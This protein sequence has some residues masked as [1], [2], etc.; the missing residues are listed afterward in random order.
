M[1]GLPDLDVMFLK[2]FAAIMLFVYSQ[3]FLLNCAALCSVLNG[4]FVAPAKTLLSCT[5]V[6]L[7]TWSFL[8]SNRLTF[9]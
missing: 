8:D 5:Y 1:K 3:L 2:I 6:F 9:I 7:L 4:H